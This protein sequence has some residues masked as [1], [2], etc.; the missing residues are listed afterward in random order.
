MKMLS[1]RFKGKINDFE[2]NKTKLICTDSK[3]SLKIPFTVF[4]RVMFQKIRAG[5]V[6]FFDKTRGG[7]RVGHSQVAD[8]MFLDGL[9]DAYENG[10]LMG[11][12]AEDCAEK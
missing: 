9:E 6:I 8:H 4:L 10:R 11:S 5:S 2:I 3:F 7:A 1:A 12:F